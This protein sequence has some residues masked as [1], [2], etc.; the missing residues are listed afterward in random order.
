MLQVQPAVGPLVVV[1]S[2]AHLR[3]FSS[4]KSLLGFNKVTRNVA[5]LGKS[6]QSCRR[7]EACKPYASVSFLI[8]WPA[9]TPS[10]KLTYRFCSMFEVN[11]GQVSGLHSVLCSMPFVG[12]TAVRNTKRLGPLPGRKL[13]PRVLNACCE[14]FWTL[15]SQETLHGVSG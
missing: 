10:L 6:D 2:S 3:A 5:M 8:A 7:A 12:L 9:A 13:L 4:C 15:W 11:F 14:P 1:E